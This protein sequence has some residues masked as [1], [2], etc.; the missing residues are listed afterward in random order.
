MHSFDKVRF[1]ED[2]LDG[3]V[4]FDN[5]MVVLKVRV[6]SSRCMYQVEMANKPIPMGI[7]Q[8]RPRFDGESPH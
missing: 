2:F 3:V 8:T 4:S 5:D 7:T 6:K 1:L